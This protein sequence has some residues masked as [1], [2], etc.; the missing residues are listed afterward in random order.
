MTAD[1][2]DRAAQIIAATDAAERGYELDASDVAIGHTI[3]MSLDAAG[4]LVSPE[5]DAAVAAR[6]LRQIRDEMSRWE[7]WDTRDIGHAFLS[8]SV[9][10]A[11]TDRAD[12]IEREAG[13][14]DAN[15]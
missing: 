2:I 1:H 15:G 7:G 5:H 12:Q 10:D 4:R 13:E 9:L 3:A 14:S 11:L 8:E 6:A